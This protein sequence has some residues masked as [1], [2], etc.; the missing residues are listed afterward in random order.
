[1]ASTRLTNV[2]DHLCHSL[3]QLVFRYRIL[4]RILQHL[5]WSPTQHPVSDLDHVCELDGARQGLILAN[6][7]QKLSKCLGSRLASPACHL[8]GGQEE[9]TT[10][11]VL[12]DGGL[13]EGLGHDGRLIEL[14]T[15]TEMNEWM[16]QTCI[17]YYSR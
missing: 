1:M 8:L 6:L 14:K 7:V 5:L 2:V 15:E 9:I 4:R 16:D 3:F 12:M 17:Q 13:G 11:L 10:K